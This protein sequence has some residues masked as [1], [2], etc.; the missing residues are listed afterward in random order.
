M[1]TSNSK[2]NPT[3]AVPIE[4]LG[5]GIATVLTDMVEVSVNMS[6]STF[7]LLKN[8]TQKLSDKIKPSANEK[9]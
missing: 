8:G 3:I 4:S 7:V 2:E 5:T 6:K 1:F 9:K